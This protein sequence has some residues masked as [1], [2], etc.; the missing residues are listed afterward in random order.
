MADIVT[1]KPFDIL[2]QTREALSEMD[3]MFTRPFWNE[4]RADE[5]TLPLDIYEQADELVVEAS[6]P[7]FRKEDIS[8]QLHQGVL[9]IV[10]RPAAE[11]GSYADAR[12]YRRERPAGSWSRRVAL[13]GVVHD[14]AM[15]AELRDGVLRLRIPVPEAAK[16]KQIEITG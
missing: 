16:P 3:R 2:E 5:G 10:A 13:P 1:R 6:V 11:A 4:W 12:Y 8:L 9:S 15:T 7:G 14:A